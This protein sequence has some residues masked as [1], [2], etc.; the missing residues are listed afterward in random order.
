[1][2][3]FSPC[4]APGF[5]VTYIP[6]GDLVFYITWYVVSRPIMSYATMSERAFHFVVLLC[7]CDRN[8]DDRWWSGL[9]A[10]ESVYLVFTH[11][12]VF[13][14]SGGGL[15]TQRGGGDRGEGKYILYLRIYLKSHGVVDASVV[16]S[17]S[18]CV[19]PRL[20]PG[21]F[22]CCAAAASAGDEVLLQ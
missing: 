8:G 7:V 6:K 19:H 3:P 18:E 5:H 20:W 21:Q 15:G 4:D 22:E 17:S 1:M 11:V 9:P 12:K 13:G 10:P 2:T 14:R 16:Y